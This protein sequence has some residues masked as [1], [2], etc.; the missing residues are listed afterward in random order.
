[1]ADVVT[2]TQQNFKSLVAESTKPVLVDFWA[3]WCAPCRQLNPVIAQVA[4]E[5]GEDALVGKVN[6]DEERTLA[7][8]FQIMSLPSLLVF[9]GGAKVEEFVGGRS[10]EEL[11]ATLRSHA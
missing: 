11:V 6:V 2:I 3:P 10:A 7:A 5:L 4:E 8:M 9:R 1:M